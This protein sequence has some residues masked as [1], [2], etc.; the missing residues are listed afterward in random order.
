MFS[1]VFAWGSLMSASVGLRTHVFEC[2]EQQLTYTRNCFIAAAL[3]G[4]TLALSIWQSVLSSRYNA[5]V[6][7]FNP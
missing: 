3:Y 7:T 6:A 4:V 2:Y 1:D 5:R